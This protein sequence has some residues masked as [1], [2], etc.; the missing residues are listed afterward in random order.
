MVK[1]TTLGFG[2]PYELS[3]NELKLLKLFKGCMPDQGI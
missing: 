1:L 2:N 3:E